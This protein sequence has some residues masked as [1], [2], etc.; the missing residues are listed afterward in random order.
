MTPL[1]LLQYSLIG[2]GDLFV[3]LVFT[4]ALLGFCRQSIQSLIKFYFQ[5]YEQMMHRMAKAS[6]Q[7]PMSEYR[8]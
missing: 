7:M 6:I 3:V 5:E 2:T 8:A 1:R 4:A